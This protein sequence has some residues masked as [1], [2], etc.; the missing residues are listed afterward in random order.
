MRGLRALYRP[1]Y[2]YKKAGIMLLELRVVQGGLFD[3][4]DT[5]RSRARMRAIDALNR[6]FGR[7]TVSFAAAGY[8]RAWGL[9]RDFISPRFTTNWGE[10]LRV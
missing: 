8:R 7:D 2:C 10:L 4:P 1:G 3:P 9:R 6:R 5:V